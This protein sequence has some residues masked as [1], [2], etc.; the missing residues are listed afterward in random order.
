MH[1]SFKDLISEASVGK[2]A[3]SRASVNIVKYL[4]KHL[5]KE[6]KPCDGNI[7]AN[8]SGTYTGYLFICPADN[9]AIRVNWAGTKFHSINVWNNYVDEVSP[10]M[11]I[12]TGKI[13][14]G[15]ASFARL[16]PEIAAAIKD[17][18]FASE[19]D[20]PMDELAE[21]SNVNEAYEYNGK[22]YSTKVDIVHAMYDEGKSVEEIKN[23]VGYPPG[24]IRNL[25]AR[26]KGEL[27]SVQKSK[28]GKVKVVKG[29]PETIL[30]NKG[31][32]K[33]DEVLDDTEYA[34]PQIVF[35]D[36][37][38][39]VTL[40]GRRLIPALLITGQ[41]GVGKSF[42]VTEILN[43][44]GSKGKE[45]VIMKGRCTPAAMYKFL[46]NHYNQI[47]V[48]DDCD[49]VFGSE[50]GMNVLKGALD[51]GNPR[52]ISWMTK[53]SD[54]VDTFGIESHEECEQ[55]LAAWSAENKGRDGTPSY[56]Q[57]RGGVIFISNLTKRDIYKKDR[58][59][60]S[61]CTVV[62]IVLRAKDV[63][64]RIETVLPHIKVYD[65]DGHN[66]ANDEGKKIVFDFIKSDEFQNHPKMR[67]K[68][69]NFRM[70]NQVY[71][72]WYAGF[73]NWKDLSFRAGG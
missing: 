46:Y 36:L 40:V 56:Y 35:S 65:I 38:Q 27:G 6:F 63:I 48:F 15:E 8:G 57:F 22:T 23:A 12:F 1:K 43:K 26:Y 9:A 31:T 37:Q 33:A 2:A 67:G 32:Q 45:Y 51:S 42:T 28:S 73:E 47:C 19:D 17:R 59:I 29:V 68:E 21:S 60:L 4:Q 5:D 53:G 61:R 58:A 49:S 70:F 72:Y 62:D 41:G 11:E 34:D 20:E 64:N 54:I 13:A 18:G 25:I 10:A 16:L 66:I 39:Y 7:Y 14:P 69:V 50:D 24:H 44:Y 30:P 71:T 3:I 55:A 52:E